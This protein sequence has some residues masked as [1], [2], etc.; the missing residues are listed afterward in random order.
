M[1]T[2]LQTH[3]FVVHC[4]FCVVPLQEELVQYSNCNADDG[5][6]MFHYNGFCLVGGDIMLMLTENSQDLD[7]TVNFENNRLYYF[8]SKYFVAAKFQAMGLV[9]MTVW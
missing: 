4:C 9:W 1:K 2:I 8:T 7:N 6:G 3:S 5:S